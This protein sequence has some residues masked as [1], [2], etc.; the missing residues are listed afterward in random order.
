MMEKLGLAADAGGCVCP[1]TVADCAERAVDGDSVVVKGEEFGL[2]K[3]VRR[4]TASS[5]P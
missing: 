2:E 4:R 5:E 1:R 3:N